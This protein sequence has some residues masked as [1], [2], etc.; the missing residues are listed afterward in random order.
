MSVHFRLDT[1][2]AENSS[3]L[4]LF[5]A[6]LTATNRGAVMFTGGPVWAMDWL[7]QATSPSQWLALSAYKD[8]DEVKYSHSVY[9]G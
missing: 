9:H 6:T 8:L 1:E 7:P 2:E 3:S 4:P 5:Q